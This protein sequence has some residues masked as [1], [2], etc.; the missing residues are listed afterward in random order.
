[1]STGISSANSY[2]DRHLNGS[3]SFDALS[4]NE[5]R[6]G[7]AG[8]DSAFLRQQNA[9][10]KPTDKSSSPDSSASTVNDKDVYVSSS[11]DGDKAASSYP[12]KYKKTNGEALNSQETALL[13]QLKRIDQNVRRH[14]AAHV[15]AGGSYVTKGASFSYATG[16]DGNH[17]AVA[18][19]VSIDTSAE[20]DPQA[21]LTKMRVVQRAALAP[22]DPSP[23]DR[24]VAAMATQMASAAM[25][26]I[27]R[28]QYEKTMS[29]SNP[30]STKTSGS[31]VDM[32]V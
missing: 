8:D 28:L 10:S 31:M 15:A 16:P 26:E 23:Q 20:R 6:K 13:D 11:N 32:Y 14:E 24:A 30:Q 12:V 25:L 1:M 19:E 2:V 22:M 21:T 18:G 5:D 27:A 29:S 9:N 7:I 4:A 3:R 17:Y